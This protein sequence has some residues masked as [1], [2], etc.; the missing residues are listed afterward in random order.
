M[1]GKVIQFPGNKKVP[2]VKVEEPQVRSVSIFEYFEV[3][4]VNGLF[5]KNDINEADFTP[6][7]PMMA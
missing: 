5:F 4:R 3:L 2:P 7:E 1:A 6:P